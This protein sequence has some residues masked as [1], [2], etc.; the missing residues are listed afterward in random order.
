MEGKLE[1]G[2]IPNV[3]KLLGEVYE[4][5]RDALAEFVTNSI[6]AKATKVL[7]EIN[8]NKK[9]PYVLISDD[10]IGMTEKDLERIAKNIGFSIKR[11][12]EG[13]VGEKGIGILG[14]TN[15]GE[16]LKIISRTKSSNPYSLSIN[17]RTAQ[18][19]LVKDKL[20]SVGTNVYIN[21]IDTGSRLIS[22]G[23]LV[24]YFKEKF[25]HYLTRG[26]IDLTVS[27]GKRSI[28]VNP[29]VYKGER[30]PIFEQETNYGLVT[31]SL[32]ILPPRWDRAANVSVYRK[33]VQVVDEVNEIPELDNQVW[34]KNRI[35]GEITAD[36]CKITSGRGGFVRDREF[37]E[38]VK[39]VK[40][41]EAELARVI[42]EQDKK[43]RSKETK[44]MYKRLSNVFNRVL[45]E[46]TEFEKFPVQIRSESGK[47]EEVEPT[48]SKAPFYSGSKE[49]KKENGKSIVGPG[50]ELSKIKLGGGLNWEEK[51]LYDFPE[52]R[53]HLDLKTFRAILINTIHPDYKAVEDDA[54]NKFAY[55]LKLTAK[56]LALLNYRE[57]K[58]EILL[59]KAIGLEIKSEKIYWDI[60]GGS[61][62]GSTETP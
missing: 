35:Q 19:S 2:D 12:M 10:G 61:P 51:A 56:E 59:E 41:I 13:V 60:Y 17:V 36:F 6:D 7:V 38:F 49:G 55:L 27:D 50:K 34:K 21:K 43:S 37:N 40:S 39:A 3:L 28:Q 45:D 58:A 16:S 8:K 57:A 31:F 48:G 4:D 32:F 23:K 44:E 42:S 5:P 25:R 22:Q 46:L 20:E 29:E 52:M 33:G 30:F 26:I 9:N 18:F 62:N 1:F 24:E 54:D 47:E 11:G 14:Y 53:S 15:I